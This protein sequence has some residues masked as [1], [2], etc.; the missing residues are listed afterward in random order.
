ME[1]IERRI[2]TNSI[3]SP[4]SLVKTIQIFC[5]KNSLQLESLEMHNDT[6]TIR[7]RRIALH[8]RPDRQLLV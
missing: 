2:E 4:Q 3:K 7:L 8:T 6:Y 5:I 1:V